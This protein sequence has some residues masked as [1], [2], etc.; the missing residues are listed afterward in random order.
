MHLYKFKT[1]VSDFKLYNRRIKSVNLKWCNQVLRFIGKF[2]VKTILDI[3]SCY[4][5]AYKEIKIKIIF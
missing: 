4:F 3:G 5:Q 1:R 2:D